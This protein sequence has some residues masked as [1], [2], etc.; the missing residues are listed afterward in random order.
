MP[1]SYSSVCINTT[2]RQVEKAPIGSIN[3]FR[4]GVLGLYFKELVSDYDL[5]IHYKR[6][7]YP[8]TKDLCVNCISCTVRT[9]LGHLDIV[10]ISTETV[11]SLTQPDHQV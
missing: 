5:T 6:I 8:Y 7:N 3:L 1:R 11:T 2:Q 9:S 4:R 10:I